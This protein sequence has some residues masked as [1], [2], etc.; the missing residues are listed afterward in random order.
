MPAGTVEACI[1]MPTYFLSAAGNCEPMPECPDTS[2]G[3]LDCGDAN[4][5]ICYSCDTLNHYV[6]DPDT[7]NCKC[8][9]AYFYDGNICSP[10]TTY[11]AACTYCANENLCLSCVAN[12][13]LTAGKCQCNPQY[14]LVDPDTCNLCE[15]GCLQCTAI[16]ACTICDATQNFVLVNGYCQCVPGRFFR[17]GACYLCNEIPGCVDCNNAGCTVCDT[18]FGFHLNT[19]LGC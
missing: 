19:A 14:Y 11:D 18:I 7:E 3:C 15:T 9:V 2:A 4:S 13:T 10:C 16:G 12:F 6:L 17:N 1:C 5:T 8:D